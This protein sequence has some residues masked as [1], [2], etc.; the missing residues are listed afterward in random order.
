MSTDEIV[1]FF[2]VFGFL[3]GYGTCAFGNAVAKVT[4]VKNYRPYDWAIDG[5]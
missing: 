2:S 1:L 4:P 3:C 5:E